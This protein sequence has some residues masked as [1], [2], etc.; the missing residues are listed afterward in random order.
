MECLQLN[1]MFVISFID[2]IANWNIRKLGN[3][4]INFVGFFLNMLHKFI[5]SYLNWVT[6]IG[7][8]LLIFRN[9][10]RSPQWGST[11][12]YYFS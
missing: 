12:L 7:L 9:I 5:Q 2:L 3:I 10:L 11:D 8:Y 6:L 4:A 1:R